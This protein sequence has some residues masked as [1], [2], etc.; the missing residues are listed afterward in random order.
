MRNSTPLDGPPAV[1][2]AGTPALLPKPEIREAAVPGVLGKVEV[3]SDAEQAELQANEAVID[4]GWQT[5]VEVGIALA[6]IRDA[7]LYRIEFPTFEAYC[8]EKWEYSRRRA[9]Y[10]ITAAQLFR[11]LRTNCSQIQPGHES[12]L[13]ALIG[14][15]HEQAQQAWQR[16]VEMAGQRRMTARLVK[17]AMQELQLSGD[18]PKAAGPTRQTRAQ[19]RRLIDAAIGELIVLAGQG[20]TPS[21]LT[22][23]LEALHRNIGALFPATRTRA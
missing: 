13:R 3:L 20:A 4:M 18:P 1:P 8:R 16:A 15:S 7:R 10:L 19:I 23:K 17:K 6:R 2:A 9:D 12:Q 22:T 5:F 21:I 11:H 14:L